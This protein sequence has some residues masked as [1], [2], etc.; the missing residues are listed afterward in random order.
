MKMSNITIIEKE[1]KRVLTTEQLAK[2]YEVEPIR[3]QQGFSRNEYRFK[4]GKHYFKLKGTELKEFKT[5]YL[6][7]NPSML[8]INC[9]YLWTERGANR[10]CKILDIDKAW[11]Q[12]DNLEETYFRV[13]EQKQLTPMDQLRLQ[14]EVLEEHQEKLTTIESKVNN[15]ENHMTIDYG[16]QLVLQQLAKARAIQEMGGKDTCCYKDR[17]LRSKVFSRVWKDF[18][19]YLAVNS[20]RNTPKK[21]FDKAKEYL[22]DWK[23]QGKLL[24]EIEESN[25]QIILEEI[26]CTK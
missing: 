15:L 5:T 9:L 11:E 18:K 7:D 14:Y 21:D 8:R 3:I 26:A 17:S 1:G 19:D 22:K 24:R 6:K 25:S 10:H 16:E 4:E 2:I 13:K 20:Y 12:F 23:A